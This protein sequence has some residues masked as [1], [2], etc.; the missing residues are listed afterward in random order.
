VISTSK[1]ILEQNEI[2]CEKCIGLCTDGIQSI[3]GQNAGL[4]ALIG[5]KAYHIIWTHCML[6]NQ[7]LACRNMRGAADCISNLY[8]EL[9]VH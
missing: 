9:T 8:A 2:N 7:E 5:K 4:R 6:H 3:S 1:D